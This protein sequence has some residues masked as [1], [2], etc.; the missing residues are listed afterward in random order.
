MPG[1]TGPVVAAAEREAGEAVTWV[2][3]RE[4]LAAQL[5]GMVKSGDVVLTMGAG[6]ITGVGREL[7][8]TLEAQKGAG[9]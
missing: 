3:R 8:A 2:P 6:D 9:V 1:D 5:A 4:E 7:I